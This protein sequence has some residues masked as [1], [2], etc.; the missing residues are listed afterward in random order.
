[1][2]QMTYYMLDTN[3]VSYTIK[4]VE[5]VRRNLSLVPMTSICISA[6]T[7]AELLHGLAKKRGAT[8]LHKL[9]HEFLLRVEILSWDSKAAQTYADFRML[10]ESQGKSLG[11]MDMLIAAH[12]KSIDATL[13]T[14]DKAFYQLGGLLD[15]ADWS[16]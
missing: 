10:Y 9:V 11:S 16:Q 5:S 4:G 1:M 3:M 8:Q 2:E 6:I 14:N 15:V 12:C 7:E 13:V